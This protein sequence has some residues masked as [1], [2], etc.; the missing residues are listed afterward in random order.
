[1]TAGE[2]VLPEVEAFQALYSLGVRELVYVPDL[3]PAGQKNLLKLQEFIEVAGITFYQME[4]SSQRNV[5]DGEKD[6]KGVI[7]RLLKTHDTPWT[8]SVL[9]T[10]VVVPSQDD[11]FPL[12]DLGKEKLVPYAMLIPEF[13]YSGVSHTLHGGAGVGKTMVALGICSDLI[14]AGKRILYCDQ[15]NGVQVVKRRLLGL[16]ITDTQMSNQFLYMP[17]SA[18]L[19]DQL[20][21]FVRRVFDLSCDL[22]VLDSGADFYQAAGLEENGNMEILGWFKNVIQ[23]LAEK[24]LAT[25]LLE[26]EGA[27]GD[28]SR[29]RGA[30]SKKG[31]TEVAW[32]VKVT[33]AFNQNTVGSLEFKNTK[34]RHGTLPELRTARI[35]G[36]GV[37]GID[38]HMPPAATVILPTQV[39]QRKIKQLWSDIDRVLRQSGC[40]D[41]ATGW[42]QSQLISMLPPTGMNTKDLTEAIKN[43]AD[44]PLTRVRKA[45][46][47]GPRA[48]IIL[49]VT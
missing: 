25:L 41:Q 11:L 8:K 14:K 46:K 18:P 29:P 23:A 28:D 3:D 2:G 1:L 10:L 27:G 48:R 34:D 19:Q 20:F 16:G 22:S 37:G 12:I 39:Q 30:T 9:D 43:C 7:S 49:W 38:F 13:I 36:D 26:H 45:Q 17:F 47:P 40:I 21:L 24:G 4:L 35:G 15:E 42:N 33:Q 6:A 32:N 5:L 44:S 31:K